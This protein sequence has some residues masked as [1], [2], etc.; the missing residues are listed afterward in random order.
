MKA[1]ALLESDTSTVAEEM[2]TAKLDQI[3]LVL[4]MLFGEDNVPSSI[5]SS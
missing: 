5:T 1:R 2:I 3:P 4:K